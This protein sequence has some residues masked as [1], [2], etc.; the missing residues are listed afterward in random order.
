MLLLAN[1]KIISEMTKVSRGKVVVEAKEEGKY[2]ILDG[3]I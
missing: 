2:E 1:C 3:F